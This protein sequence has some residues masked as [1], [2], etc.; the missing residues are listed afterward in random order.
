MPMQSLKSQWSSFIHYP[1]PW[2]RKALVLEVLV[3]EN[4]TALQEMLK[5]NLIHID[6]AHGIH[7]ASK[8]I[9]QCYPDLCMLAFN[10]DEPLAM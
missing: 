5:T 3:T 2:L 4:D 7:E 9:D 1:L 10:G 8:A 6:G